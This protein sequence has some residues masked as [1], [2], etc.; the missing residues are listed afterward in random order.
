[1][2]QKFYLLVVAL[3]L[4]IGSAWAQTPPAVASFDFTSATQSIDVVYVGDT[5][6]AIRADYTQGATHR[7]QG[8]IQWTWDGSAV[9]M[10]SGATAAGA[11]VK[12]DA[13]R[14][15][16]VT[17]TGTIAPITPVPSAVQAAVD[18]N[19]LPASVLNPIVIKKTITIKM[20]T[21]SINPHP[22]ILYISQ[23]GTL[24]ATTE[25]SSAVITGYKVSPS[26]GFTV[27]ATGVYEAKAAAEYT[28]TPLFTYKSVPEPFE[29]API[30][31]EVREGSVALSGDSRVGI[32]ATSNTISAGFTPST[33]SYS[34]QTWTSSNENV[35][36]IVTKGANSMTYNAVGAGTAI[37]TYTAKT[38]YNSTGVVRATKTIQVTGGVEFTKQPQSAVISGGADKYTLNAG[39]A[40]LPGFKNLTYQWYKDGQLIKD[41]TSPSYT[42]L[43]LNA[44]AGDYYV[45]V[46]AESNADATFKYVATSEV[47][48]VRR[49][50]PLPE[51]VEFDRVPTGPFTTDGVY[52]FSVKQ[53]SDAMM[54][55]W[56]SKNGT[57]IFSSS[58]GN[59]VTAQFTQPGDEVI[60]ARLIHRDALNSDK[61]LFPIETEGNKEEEN[62]ESEGETEGEGTEGEGEETE[63][64]G[65]EGTEEEVEGEE[66]EVS[67][68]SFP[69]TVSSPTGSEAI[70]ATAFTAYPNPTSGQVTVTGLAAGE[71]IKVYS[72]SGSLVAT[73]TAT[74][75]TSV[76]DL[77]NLPQ[78]LYSLTTTK[79]AVKIIKN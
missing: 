43:D 50:I 78:G 67:S 55:L 36:K 70:A 74:S 42:I 68:A 47:A 58:Q 6:I 79:G 2:K 71:V 38:A 11:Q 21:A 4:T 37:I 48:T 61:T 29:G 72:L 16:T 63:G 45:V 46:T 22:G 69:V 59:T 27:D 56:S 75:E 24:S 34:D 76:I 49:V 53:Y 40:S 7:P 19:E 23:T 44:G 64:E 20:P 32:G 65:E 8:Q 60:I 54:C 28:V 12:L 39:A 25:P 14:P 77:T 35:I 57:V 73:F 17:V 3:C 10:S 1:M 18:A 52:T 33:L 41:A 66:V 15:G 26:T 9:E 31:I 51:V 30:K 13:L 5:E 62:K